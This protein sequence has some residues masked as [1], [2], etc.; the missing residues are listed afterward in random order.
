MSTDRTT[1][2]LSI[3]EAQAWLDAE[4]CLRS[5][6]RKEAHAHG[7]MPVRAIEGSAAPVI[8]GEAAYHTTMSGRTVVRCP[9]SYGWR[10]WYHASTK[11]VEVG[12]DYVASI[13]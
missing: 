9:N 1:A 2:P 13:M 11:R 12:A 7:S 10:T 6:C 8:A 3:E 4:R 5:R